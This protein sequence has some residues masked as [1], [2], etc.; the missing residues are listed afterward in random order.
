MDQQVAPPPERWISERE[1]EKRMFQRM[2][3]E[4]QE[5]SAIV[6]EDARAAFE[7]SRPVQTPRARYGWR[8]LVGTSFL[9][10]Q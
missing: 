8:G 7:L 9:G 2:V 1:W 6:Y 5:R 10:Q 4:A 3:D